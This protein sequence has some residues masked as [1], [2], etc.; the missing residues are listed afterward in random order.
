MCQGNIYFM[1]GAAAD[2][3]QGLESSWTVKTLTGSEKSVKCSAST[4][5]NVDPLKGTVK[6]CFCDHQKDEHTTQEI[7]DVI[8]YWE[9]EKGLQDIADKIDD[10]KED[11]KNTKDEADDAVDT[12]EGLV[13]KD[14][15]K[16]DA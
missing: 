4:F 10:A 1:N 3:S 11:A 15:E 6:Q 13:D 12:T 9:V 16:G 8:E 14:K 2:F 7:A 5:A